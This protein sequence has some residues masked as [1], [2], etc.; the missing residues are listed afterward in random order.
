ML[1]IKVNDESTLTLF[2]S[3]PLIMLDL[4]IMAPFFV[5]ALQPYFANPIYH[6]KAK[7]DQ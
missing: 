4:N 3:E 1:P 5:T 6:R 7:K 2:K